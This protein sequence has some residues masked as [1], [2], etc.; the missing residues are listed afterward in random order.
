MVDVSHE[1]RWGR[2]AEG[3]GEDPYLELGDGRRAREGRAG[4]RLQRAG[5]GR[6]ERQALRGLRP[7]GGRAR[8][9]HDRHVRAAAAQLLP[10]AVQGRDRRGRGHR[11]VLV[12]RHQRRPGLREP[13]DG[14][15]HP[16]ARVG[17]RRLHRERLH[18]RRRAARLPA[19]DAGR[20]P[21]RPRRRGRR[22]RTRRRRR[23]TPAPTPR[24]SARTCATTARELLAQRPHL[25]GA[26]RRRRAPDPAREVPRRA[27]RP[28]VRRPG[29]GRRRAAPARRGRRR[30]ARRPAARWSCSR[31]TD[32]TA[33]ARPGEEDRGDRAAGRQTST[34]CSARGGAGRGH[35]RG[36]RPRRHHG[37]EPGRDRTRRAAS[38]SN[39][40][41]PDNDA[42]ER[43]RPD[44]RLR[45]GG[46][47][48]RAGRPG[49]ARA[50]R[51]RGR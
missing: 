34:T 8:L 49:R 31:T 25:D 36:H 5:Q 50:R 10:A 37:P 41:P 32:D 21:V 51:E 38:S 40:E 15:R 46:R 3:G 28:P 29:E 44:A 7:A 16:Q 4:Q 45:R 20:G 39:L 42:G 43:V 11:D 12:Q 33:A 27:V 1:P 48:R 6:H 18:R 30:R 24:W 22:R 14:D 23:S 26:A 35:R 47:R 19:E 13:G 2:I 9:Q 17:L